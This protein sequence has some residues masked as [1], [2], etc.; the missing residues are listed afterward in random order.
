MFLSRIETIRSHG[1]EPGFHNGVCQKHLA[2]LLIKNSINKLEFLGM[3]LISHGFA[4]RKELEN[5]K[6]IVMLR[7][8]QLYVHP[9][10]G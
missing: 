3:G 5:S 10:L 2:K 9:Q 7:V 1:G 6:G 4:K 8:P